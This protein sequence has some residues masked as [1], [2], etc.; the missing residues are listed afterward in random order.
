MSI[1]IPEISGIHCL[2]DSSFEINVIIKKNCEAATK[3]LLSE[4]NAFWQEEQEN[5]NLN[6]KLIDKII[7]FW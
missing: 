6:L 2:S 4:V 3:I 5:I 1:S 7:N